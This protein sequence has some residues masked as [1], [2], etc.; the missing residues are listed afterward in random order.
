MGK[1]ASYRSLRMSHT[2]FLPSLYS[3]RK[4]GKRK[5]H[6]CDNKRT[7]NENKEWRKNIF[8]FKEKKIDAFMFYVA[9]FTLHTILLR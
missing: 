7:E 2:H 8:Y 3:R 5:E 6:L 4:R 9:I 1:E